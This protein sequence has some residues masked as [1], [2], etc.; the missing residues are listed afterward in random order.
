MFCKVVYSKKDDLSASESAHIFPELMRANPHLVYNYQHHEEQID[1]KRPE[2]ELLKPPEV[3]S[4]N[5]VLFHSG[6]LIP[7]ER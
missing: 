5:K 3:A 4:G 1:S 6:E 2:N 7:F